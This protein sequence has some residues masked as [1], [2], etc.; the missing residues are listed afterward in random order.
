MIRMILEKSEKVKFAE[1][2]GIKSRFV[3]LNK[4]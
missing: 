3:Y 1:K 4:L 2:L